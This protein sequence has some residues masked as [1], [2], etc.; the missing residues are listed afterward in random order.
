VSGNS[1]GLKKLWRENSNWSSK[2]TKYL[3]ISKDSKTHS[4]TLHQKGLIQ[5][6]LKKYGA[7]DVKK[8]PAT[9]AT[10][11]L[12]EH[13][14]NSPLMINKSRYLSLVMS[15]MYLAR[16]TRPDILMPN[17]YLATRCSYPTEENWK[18]LMRI[19]YYLAGT[20][21]EGL[22]YSSKIPF[23]PILSVDASH[24]L[25]SEG[26][27]QQAMVISNGSDPVGFRSK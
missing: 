21:D 16:F 14:K 2:M 5:S 7:D 4:V 27:G 17:S 9:P 3:M 18:K 6:I 11:T 19:V 10:A 20:Q 13:D 12:M 15:L 24:H 26:H 23:K 1:L 25:Y 8:P 22:T